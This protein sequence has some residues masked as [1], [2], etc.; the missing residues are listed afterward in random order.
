MSLHAP[1]TPVVRFT[2]ACRTTPW[3]R[4]GLAVVD[5][6]GCRKFMYVT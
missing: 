1:T 5:C 3:K 2:S 6:H 4:R